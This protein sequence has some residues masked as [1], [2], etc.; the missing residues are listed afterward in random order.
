MVPET[1]KR[2]GE[3]KTYGSQCPQ[4]RSLV[5]LDCEQRADER[6]GQQRSS[7]PEDD[8][9]Q[10]RGAHQRERQERLPNARGDQAAPRGPGCAR[11]HSGDQ[12]DVDQVADVGR[13][14]D[15][16]CSDGRRVAGDRRDHEPGAGRGQRE[17]E[18]VVGDPNRRPAVQEL[19]DRRRRGDD[20]DAGCPAE[21][22]DRRQS[23]HERQ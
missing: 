11:D 6:Q 8:E 7:L 13:G 21:Q 22:H 2:I 15:A 9:R 1:R 4:E 10:N 18:R 5:E 23:E 12:K 20:E 16:G 19:H 14:D 17:C 3:C